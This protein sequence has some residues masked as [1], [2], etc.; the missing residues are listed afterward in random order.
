MYNDSVEH[1][2]KILLIVQ[3][4]YVQVKQSFLTASGRSSCVEFFFLI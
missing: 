2:Q 3:F 1:V 4:I